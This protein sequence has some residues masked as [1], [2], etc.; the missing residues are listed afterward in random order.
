MDDTMLP[1]L[2]ALKLLRG[3]STTLLAIQ[4]VFVIF[5]SVIGVLFENDR[6]RKGCR[7]LY[8]SLAFFVLSVIV[9]LN[10]IGTIPWSTQRL[11]NLVTV[12]HDIY[13][14]P[15]YLGVPIWILAFCQHMCFLL[16]LLSFA[17]FVYVCMRG[18]DGLQD[19]KEGTS[20]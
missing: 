11:P 15:N 16:G 20:R 2:E 9:A 7:P 3:W 6:T 12:Y 14:F 5:L 8:T 1:Y 18:S 13:Q 10:V 19:E 4:T 17:Y